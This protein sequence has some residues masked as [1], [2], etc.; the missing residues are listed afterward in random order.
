[1]FSVEAPP[2]Q[3]P[4]YHGFSGSVELTKTKSGG[5]SVTTRGVF[6]VNTAGNAWVVRVTE[7]PPA[8]CTGVVKEKLKA[9]GIPF[10]DH[11]DVD[12]VNL[13]VEF[14]SEAAARKWAE[15]TCLH[16]QSLFYNLVTSGGKVVTFEGPL[17]FIKM[18]VGFRLEVYSKRKASDVEALE[19]QIQRDLALI[20]FITAFTEERIVVTRLKDDRD[21]LDT[22]KKEAPL[23]SKDEYRKPFMDMPLG[24]LTEA[25]RKKTEAA[26]ERNR[27]KLEA[28]RSI[29]PT[30][31]WMKELFEAF[32]DNREVEEKVEA[33][34]DLISFL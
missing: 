10:V 32:P 21:I 8:V 24:S 22:L 12:T 33:F 9:A 11:G 2:Q 7:L 3:V 28:M 17:D 29:T 31:I 4:W 23:A 16:T 20:Q 34:K 18:Y 26:C 1:M 30:K 14:D 13:S 5:D 19:K 15:S 27:K 6:E 25:N